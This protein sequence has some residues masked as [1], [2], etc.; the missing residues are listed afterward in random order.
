MPAQAPQKVVSKTIFR[1]LNFSSKLHWPAK[2]AIGVPRTDT[3]SI[4]FRNV[5]EAG[6]GKRVLKCAAV[7]GMNH[8]LME[9]DVHSMA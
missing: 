3:S 4:V 1:F 2:C 5:D 8:T 7:R 6:V 9:V